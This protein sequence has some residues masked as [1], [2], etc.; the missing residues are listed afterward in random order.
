M[1]RLITVGIASPQQMLMGTTAERP[2]STNPGVQYY[3]TTSNQL[4]IYNGSAWHPVGDYQRISISANTNA[5][6]NRVYLVSTASGPVTL[7]LPATPTAGDY[8]RVQD[9]AGT[10]GS[11]NL[12]VARNG[13]L[14]MRQTDDMVITTNGAS[15]GLIYHDVTSGWLIESI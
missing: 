4:E 11:N 6:A 15:F 13:N 10:F 2:L 3:N 7:T 9:A 8:I 14:I 12:T 1:G 5:V